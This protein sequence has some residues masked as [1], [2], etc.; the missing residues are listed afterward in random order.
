MEYTEELRNTND[1]TIER[2]I[3]LKG[4]IGYVYFTKRF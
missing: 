2:V 1:N 4:V 3:N